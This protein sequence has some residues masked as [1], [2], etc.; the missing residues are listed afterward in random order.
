MVLKLSTS[1]PSQAA[2]PAPTAFELRTA[3]RA[4]LQP[5]F[6]ALCPGSLGAS[7]RP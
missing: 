7:K 6:E 5:A 2:V 4:R 1:L 3:H